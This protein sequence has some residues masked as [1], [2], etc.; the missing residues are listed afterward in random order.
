V[1]ETREY[2]LVQPLLH[3]LATE[4]PKLGKLKVKV[5]HAEMPTDLSS[6]PAQTG[7]I[8]RSDIIHVFLGDIHAPVLDGTHPWRT[9]FG[10]KDAKKGSYKPHDIPRKGRVDAGRLAE[11]E[12]WVAPLMAAPVAPVPEAALLAAITG[13]AWLLEGEKLERWSDDDRLLNKSAIEWL[14]RYCGDTLEPGGFTTTGQ[15]VRGADI[16]DGA[17]ADLNRWLDILIE[18]NK[19]ADPPAFF[20]IGGSSQ[21]G[22]PRI[23]LVQLGD[24]YDFWIGLQ[25]IGDCN[26]L[27]ECNIYKTD[28]GVRNKFL[29]FWKEQTIETSTLAGGGGGVKKLLELRQH[30]V[31]TVY[32]RGNHDNYNLDLPDR[33]KEEGIYAE[34]GHAID[35]FNHDGGYFKGWA[36]TQVAFMKPDVRFIVDPLLAFVTKYGHLVPS[37]L[38]MND[39]AV[40]KCVTH[41]LKH[42]SPQRAMLTYVQAHTHEPHLRM[43]TLAK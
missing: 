20:Q 25:R 35:M 14:E 26:L 12:S 34:H 41:R 5:L 15:R 8:P 37:R 18:Y 38:V 33:Y 42:P 9:L 7:E 30:G 17:G 39:R 29:D 16:F 6:Q 32:L 24:C 4:K 27:N 31:D 1:K 11:L 40:D 2:K 21:L 19:T 13:S 23:K 36:L 3:C 43:I 28:P 10:H 22:R